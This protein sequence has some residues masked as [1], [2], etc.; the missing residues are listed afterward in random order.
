MGGIRNSWYGTRL[1]RIY[2]NMRSRCLNENVPCYEYYGGKGVR[3]CDEWLTSFESF[4]DWALSNGY[5]EYLTLDRVNVS[6]D[7]SPN[8][9]RWISML[10]QA[11]NKERSISVNVN[12]RTIQLHQL[13]DETGISY[14]TLYWR[15]KNNKD[16]FGGH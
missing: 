1:Y 12:G 9:C 10:E 7:Y 4:R 14:N 16:L 3:I 8:N 5:E 13:A 11:K 15:Y 2:Y 6:G